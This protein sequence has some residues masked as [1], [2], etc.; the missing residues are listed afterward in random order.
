ME[1]LSRNGVEF[2]EKDIRSDVEAMQEMVSMNSQATPTTVI[3][4]DVIIGFDQEK[5]SEKLG[6]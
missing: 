6:L 1:F 2:T 5:I 3:D 4:G